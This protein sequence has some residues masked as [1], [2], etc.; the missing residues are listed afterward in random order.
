MKPS[1]GL[2]LVQMQSRW[3]V[4]GHLGLVSHKLICKCGLCAVDKTGMEAYGFEK[5]KRLED[6]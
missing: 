3:P 2:L 4:M 5:F 1:R 6:A